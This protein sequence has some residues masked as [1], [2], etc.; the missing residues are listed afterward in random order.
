MTTTTVRPTGAHPGD[1][2]QASFARRYGWP[3]GV[4]MALL[5]S[6]GAN[7]LVMFIAKADPAFAVEPDYYQ[8]AVTWD[9][10]MA[11]ARTNA[12]LGWAASGALTLAAPGT[13]GRVSVSLVGAGGTPLTDAIVSVEAMHNARASQ[14]YEAVLTAVGAGRY[15]A[16]LD[17]HRP[18]EWE[19]RVRATRGD[20]R[21]TQSLRIQAR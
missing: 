10:T 14:R 16:A 15:A 2:G 19:V 6:A 5:L 9:A 13:P 1:Q 4:A 7:I 8:K 18:G 3:I 11:Q 21:F 20:E 12:S 17:A